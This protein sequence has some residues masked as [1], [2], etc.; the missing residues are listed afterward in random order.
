MRAAIERWIGKC[1]KRMDDRG[2]RKLNEGRLGK[3]GF[4]LVEVVVS[5]AIMAIVSGSVAAFIVAGNRSYIRGNNELTLQEEAQLTANQIIDLIIDVERGIVY[6]DSGTFSEL[7]LYNEDNV[8]ML[9]W[10]GDTGGSDT[11]QVYLYEAQNT[12]TDEA[13]NTVPK[14]TEGATLQV[15]DPST[16]DAALLAQYVT[17][18][19]VDLAELADRRVTL[20]MTFEYE[21][22]TYTIAEAIKLR[23]A[24]TNSPSYPDGGPAYNWID[25]IEISPAHADMEPNKDQNFTY[26][27]TGDPEAVAQGVNWKVERVG[28]TLAAGTHFMV[29]GE[30]NIILYTGSEPLGENCLLVTCT[31]V[32]VPAMYAQATVSIVEPGIENLAISPK[33]ASIIQG[34]T[35]QFTASATKN[36]AAITPDVDWTVIGVYSDAA[37]NVLKAGTGIDANGLLTAAIDQPIGQRVLKVRATLKT[38]PTKFDET[39]VTVNPATNIDG[40]YDAKLIA[41]EL[42]TYELPD[43]SIGYKAVIECLPTWA[44]Y[45]NGYP[46]IKWYE[47]TNPGA[48][49]FGNMEDGDETQ[50]TNTLYCGTQRD[51]MAHVQA[52]VQLDENTFVSV[53]I[54]ISIPNLLPADKVNKDKPY[55]DSEN[56]VLY[57]NGMISCT[58]YNYDKNDEVVWKFKELPADLTYTVT[59]NDNISH[60]SDL[61]GFDLVEGSFDGVNNTRFITSESEGVVSGDENT[62]TV[63]AK[64]L[65]DWNTEYRLRL[66][67]YNKNTGEEIAE[68]IVLVPRFD[69]LF[70]NGSHYET[71]KSPA[72]YSRFFV[73]LYGF[74]VGQSDL[75]AEGV[76]AGGNFRTQLEAGALQAEKTISSDTKVIDVNTAGEGDY[77]ALNI[78]WNEENDMLILPIWDQ[79]RPDA[80]RYLMFIID[81]G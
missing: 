53:G 14:G 74:A 32:A 12:W 45:L 81:K 64:Y 17:A 50:F 34:K 76:G 51:T 30:G 25:S 19:S 54:D 69:I 46:K 63:R 24:V 13:G 68:S 38:D 8:Y 9:R 59:G 28:G 55:I 5:L 79:R 26:K 56:F 78:S 75:D 1:I 2:M 61:V 48:Y 66:T 71:V 15:G 3:R 73:Q 16:A 39:Y 47:T 18:F 33:D 52:E 80:V 31:S 20:N 60:T 6:S 62:V 27:M 72:W 44:D 49:T 22:R 41:R 35:L 4:T 29:D 21:G 70:T 23:N 43:G 36:G 37:D 10:Q 11:N 7:R 57:R 65:V 58:L 77:V 67:A 40:K 42:T